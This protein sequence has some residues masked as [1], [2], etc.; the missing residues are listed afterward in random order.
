MR[1]GLV[2][3]LT[4]LACISAVDGLCT[5]AAAEARPTR[6]TTHAQAAA[7]DTHPAHDD[8]LA[9]ASEL[10]HDDVLALFD[11]LAARNVRPARFAFHAAEQACRDSDEPQ[12]ALALHERMLEA[13]VVP[14]VVSFNTALAAA[15][16]GGDVRRCLA[17]MQSMR[18]RGLVPDAISYS[19]AISACR[20]AKLGSEAAGLLAAMPSDGLE[21]GELDLVNGILACA[22][23]STAGSLTSA[24]G[25]WSTLRA[26]STPP[27]ARAFGAGIALRAATADA[28]GALSLLSEREAAG[29]EADATVEARALSACGRAGAAEAA[30]SLLDR[31]EAR[32]GAAADSYCYVGAIQACARAADARRAMMVLGRADAA[33]AATVHAYGAALD[34]CARSG[35]WEDALSALEQMR[36]RNLPVDRGCLTAAVHALRRHERWEQ[37]FELLFEARASGALSPDEAPASLKAIWNRAKKECGLAQKPQE[38]AAERRRARRRKAA[39][40][41]AAAAQGSK[42]KSRAAA[43]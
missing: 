29:Y 26:Q 31:I 10:R 19:T 40:A 32:E 28:D 22:A 17:L 39:R 9:A 12:R 5:S 43:R 2:R 38:G 11:D 42:K 14:N 33:G 6:A 37:I 34:A 4:L 15:R 35:A 7:A 21:A 16:D 27:T 30:L 25:L 24:E 23:E 20:R 1:L 36:A 3:R 8:I 18:D 13:G 41:S